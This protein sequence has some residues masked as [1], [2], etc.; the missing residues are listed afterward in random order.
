MSAMVPDEPQPVEPMDGAGVMPD[1]PP[2]D[3]MSQRP[4]ADVPR[5]RVGV[6]RAL[7][8]G[9]TSVKGP[10]ARHVLAFAAS[11]IGTGERPANVNRYTRWYYGDNTAAP[12]C[13][14][15]VCYCFDQCGALS[16]VFGRHAYVPDFRRLFAA[17]GAFHRSRPRPGDLVAFDFD[18]SGSPEHMGFVERVVSGSTLQTIEGNSRDRVRRRRRSRSYV[19]G[20]AT[21]RYARRG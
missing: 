20:Y 2:Q 21:P 12:W 4:V 3:G 6:M 8:R 14:I 18:G 17:H 13:W 5:E 9:F 10:T 19:Y 16:L 15:F 7:A 11:Q 1:D